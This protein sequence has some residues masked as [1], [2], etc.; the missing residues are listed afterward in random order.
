MQKILPK[1][2]LLTYCDIVIFKKS[3][4]YSKDTSPK[5][6]LDKK[7]MV[8]HLLCANSGN[9][10]LNDLGYLAL[11]VAPTWHWLLALPGTGAPKNYSL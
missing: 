9:D 8:F 7:S 2:I 4:K 1:E 10:A 5:I 3:G 6:T 11:V